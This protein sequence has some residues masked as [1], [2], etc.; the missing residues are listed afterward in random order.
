VKNFPSNLVRFQVLTAA[1]MNLS[2]FW[3]VASSSLLEIDRR[4]RRGYALNCRSIYTRLHGATPQKS[5]SFQTCYHFRKCHVRAV[6]T[7]SLK[8]G[9]L[10]QDVAHDNSKI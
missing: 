10:L 1:S 8:P 9:F 3:D 5:L 7:M 4:F 2:V 6:T